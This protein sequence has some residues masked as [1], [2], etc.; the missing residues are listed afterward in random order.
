ML[1]EKYDP[2]LSAAQNYF[3]DDFDGEGLVDQYADTYAEPHFDEADPDKWDDAFGQ[4]KKVAPINLTWVIGEL[5][6]TVGNN[7]GRID[8][9]LKRL[10][11]DTRRQMRPGF[12]LSFLEKETGDLAKIDTADIEIAHIVLKHQLGVVR[13]LMLRRE[14]ETSFAGMKTRSQSRGY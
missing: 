3:G 8:E 11:R 7:L 5:Q 14:I 2:E 9:E 6:S 4:A 13:A 1:P 10:Q 12:I